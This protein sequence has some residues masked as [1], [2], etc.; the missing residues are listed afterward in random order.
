MLLHPLP[1][2]ARSSICFLG[3]WW[4]LVGFFG[5]WVGVGGVV[6]CALCVCVLWVGVGGRWGVLGGGAFVCLWRGVERVRGAQR[7]AARVV[8]LV[9]IITPQNQ[10]RSTPLPPNTRPP[11]HPHPTRT[12]T[13]THIHTTHLFARAK[14]GELDG[15]APVD[16][17]VG[18][19]DVS[20]HDAAR[21]QVLEA[22][23]DLARVAPDD[24]LLR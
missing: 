3:W 17:D 10:A 18:A 6:C 8:A 19:L 22:L 13:H 16:Q 4:W 7:G 12:H 21:V 9:R 1:I 20:V 2:V 14:V 23:E 15:A 11:P 24:G 5:G